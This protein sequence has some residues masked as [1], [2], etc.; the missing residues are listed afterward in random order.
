MID[1]VI[2]LV[3]DDD[4]VSSASVSVI[5]NTTKARYVEFLYFL[6]TS[7]CYSITLRS[8]VSI[9]PLHHVRVP[10]AELLSCDKLDLLVYKPTRDSH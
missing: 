6:H 5:K 9:T 3:V 8:P 7:Y 2:H 4:D 1:N 10:T